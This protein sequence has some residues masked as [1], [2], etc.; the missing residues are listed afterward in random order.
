MNLQ[1]IPIKQFLVT[2]AG[3]FKCPTY[4]RK[5]YCCQC[6]H[7]ALILVASVMYLSVSVRFAKSSFINLTRLWQEDVELIGRTL[8]RL[9]DFFWWKE[10]GLLSIFDSKKR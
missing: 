9:C 8:R 5:N 3:L 1:G 2:F 10:S 6:L 7:L 4:I